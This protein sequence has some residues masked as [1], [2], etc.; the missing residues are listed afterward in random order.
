[1]AKINFTLKNITKE[2][3][4]SEKKLR[5]IRR[6]AAPAE[7]KRINLELRGLVRCHRLIEQFC[8]PLV[9]YAQS[10]TTKS[11]KK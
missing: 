4:K 5:E 11:K 6:R 9:H 7:Q 1:M 8:R 2:I 3:K 10:F